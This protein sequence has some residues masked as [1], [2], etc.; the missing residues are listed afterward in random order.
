FSGTLGVLGMTTSGPLPATRGGY[1]GTGVGKPSGL[2]I[3]RGFG[4]SRGTQPS[5]SSGSGSGGKTG[6][7]IF[8]SGGQGPQP[9]Q[10]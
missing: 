3:S 8:G 5:G 4:G 2:N 9:P 10:Q 1:G 7:N 6:G